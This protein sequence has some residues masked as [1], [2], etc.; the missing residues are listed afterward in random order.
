MERPKIEDH[1]LEGLAVFVDIVDGAVEVG[2]GALVDADLLALFELDLG[3]GLVL[4][5]LGAEEDRADL[6]FR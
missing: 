3:G 4:G 2:E 5:G 6:S 1:D